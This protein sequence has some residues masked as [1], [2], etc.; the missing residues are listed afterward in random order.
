ML[1]MSQLNYYRFD[2]TKLYL[3]AGGRAEY[4][5]KYFGTL[6]EEKS[7]NNFIVNPGII[8]QN[9]QNKSPRILSEYLGLCSL[10]NLGDYLISGDTTLSTLL[11]PP[12]VP[13]IVINDNPLIKHNPKLRLIEF[14]HERN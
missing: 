9:P 6:L 13:D 14:I 4:M 11:V 8:L 1:S 10:R 5:I 2:Y 3:L 12:W 7:G